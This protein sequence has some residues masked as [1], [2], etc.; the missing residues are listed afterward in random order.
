MYVL[1]L[2]ITCISYLYAWLGHS[3]SVALCVLYT[4]LVR[5]VTSASQQ[6][7]KITKSMTSY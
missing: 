7:A 1:L 4:E 5:T 6:P 3:L 2:N